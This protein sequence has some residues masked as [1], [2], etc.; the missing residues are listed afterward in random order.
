ML[1]SNSATSGDVIETN[2][3]AVIR[4]IGCTI[5]GDYDADACIFN[6]ED[7]LSSFAFYYTKAFESGVVC[8]VVPMLIYNTEV[9]LPLSHDAATVTC[10]TEGIIDYC[11]FDCS[12]GNAEDDGGITCR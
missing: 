2:L 7:D 5:L 4:L 1:L 10:Q 8:S 6:D 3:A 9:T 12:S 11:A